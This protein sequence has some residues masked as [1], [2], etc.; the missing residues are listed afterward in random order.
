MIWTLHPSQ[1]QEMDLFLGMALY[2]RFGLKWLVEIGRKALCTDSL[3]QRAASINL[4]K[5]EKDKF[6]KKI[7]IL[8]TY[9]GDKCR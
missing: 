4:D 3:V 9:H 1:S 8:P 7:S 2:A 5:G 6:S